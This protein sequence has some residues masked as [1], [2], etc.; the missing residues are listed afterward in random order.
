M[1][2]VPELVAKLS[3]T[4]HPEGGFYK[5]TFRDAAPAPGGGGRGASTAIL[6]AGRTR[7]C[8]S[9][10]SM[11]RRRGAPAPAAPVRRRP[12]HPLQAPTPCSSRP[13]PATPAPNPNPPTPTPATPQLSRY[14]LPAGAKSK[15]HR[16]DASECWHAYM[17][18][19]PRAAAGA[20]PTDAAAGA[21]RRALGGAPRARSRR[22]AP[23]P[24]PTRPSA[25]RPPPPQKGGPI[26]IVELDPATRGA[27]TT[28]LGHDLAA[29][30]VGWRGWQKADG[31]ASAEAGARAA[32][33]P[34]AWARR[35][36]SRGPPH[37]LRPT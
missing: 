12:Q 36:T 30:Q 13:P 22:R 20:R 18:A 14:L 23:A 27:R 25:P 21:W 19:A 34:Q 10:A 26:T 6:C 5:E 9:T 3:L 8:R 29:G 37:P 16:L 32:L 1:A 7:F 35:P 24:H 33:V 17:G 15:L 4:P 31:P 11:T 2:T 28:V